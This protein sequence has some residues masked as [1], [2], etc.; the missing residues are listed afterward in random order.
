MINFKP[1]IVKMLK[2]VS[3][4]V[5]ETYPDKWEKFPI[6]IYEEENNTPHT[7][8]TEGEAL[9]LLSYRIE[10]YSNE[11][12]SVL[13]SKINDEMTRVGLTRVF[14]RDMN[15]ISGRRHTVMRYE[16]VLDL[17]TNKIYRN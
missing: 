1:E 11:S 3:K 5:S 9:T 8:T 15:D 6:L 16:G 2:K 4:N 13:K 10:I 14:S 17:E 12:T 7:T